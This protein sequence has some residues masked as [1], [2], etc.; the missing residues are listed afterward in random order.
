MKQYLEVL[1]QIL[2]DGDVKTDRTGTG[3]LSI[4][5]MQMRYNLRD[6]FPA[7]TTKKL[8]FRQVVSELLWFIEGSTNERRLAEILYGPDFTNKSTIWT[9]NADAQGVALGYQNDESV[10]ELGPVYGKQWRDF[11]GVDQLA[12]VIEQIKRTPDSRRLIVS[13][14]NPTEI[15]KMALPPCHVMYQFAVANGKLSCMMTQRS[16]DLF[17]GSPFNIASYA[18]LT[19][20]VAQ[21]CDLEVG[22]LIYSIGDAHC[23]TNHLSQAAEL[24][25]R[26]PLPLPNL[27]LN[28]EVKNIEDFKMEDIRL[29]G[30]VSHPPISAPMAV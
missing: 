3:T 2:N 14:W 24:L 9:A 29:E 12:K 16:A 1:S 13:A 17:L 10:K 7:V 25:T 23:Y 4:F 22:D 19:H 8:A 30:Y 26:D 20:M 5:G 15:E 28:P 11:G 18:L 27:W 21:V 6:G